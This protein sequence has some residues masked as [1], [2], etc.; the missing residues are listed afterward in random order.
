[1]Y[2]MSLGLY[3]QVDKSHCSLFF[4]AFSGYRCL[5]NKVPF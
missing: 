4:R 3:L 2:S 1:M 5:R